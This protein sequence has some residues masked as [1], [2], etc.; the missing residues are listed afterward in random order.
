MS[1]VGFHQIV[2]EIIWGDNSIVYMLEQLINI[3]D[4]CILSIGTDQ[5]IK[6]HKF[7]IRY[8]WTFYQII[9]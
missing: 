4:F 7:Q 3:I 6:D 1:V 5:P 2:K 8:I 9:Y